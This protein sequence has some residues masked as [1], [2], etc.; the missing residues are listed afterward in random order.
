MSAIHKSASQIAPRIGFLKAIAAADEFTLSGEPSAI[1]TVAAWGDIS[2]FDAGA[3]GR[4]YRDMGRRVRVVNAAGQVIAEYT[5]AQIV[6]GSGSE[7][8][9]DNAS[10]GIVYVQTYDAATPGNVDVVRMG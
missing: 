7:G 4:V 10:Y 3:V 1:M 5:R 6:A 2:D 9:P 8:V